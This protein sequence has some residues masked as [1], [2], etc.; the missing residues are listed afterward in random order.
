MTSSKWGCRGE[1]SESSDASDASDASEQRDLT[2]PTFYYCF[3]VATSY[4]SGSEVLLVTPYGY[5][6]AS[7]KDWQ[8]L[9]L[10]VYTHRLPP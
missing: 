4:K 8:H 3:Q 1:S 6:I 7:D 5:V 9:P 10:T 2:T